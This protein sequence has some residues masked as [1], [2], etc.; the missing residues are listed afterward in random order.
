MTQVIEINSGNKPQYETPTFDPR[1][2]FAWTLRS[3]EIT[4]LQRL[5]RQN[6]LPDPSE[7]AGNEPDMAQQVNGN[8]GKASCAR[9]Y[10]TPTFDPRGAFA[11]TLRSAEITW[12][13]SSAAAAR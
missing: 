2:A 9:R 5:Q 4:R 10:E 7:L 11:W 3:G 1:G 8:E 13:E 12:L 6:R